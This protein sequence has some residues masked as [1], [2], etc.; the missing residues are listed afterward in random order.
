MRSGS[1]FDFYRILVC[2]D[3]GLFWG[4]KLVGLCIRDRIKRSLPTVVLDLLMVLAAWVASYWLRFNLDTIP[5]HFLQYAKTSAPVVVVVQGI[6]L[7]VFGVFRGVW[8]FTSLDDLS[9]ILKAVAVGTAIIMALM[10]LTVRLGGVPRSVPFLYAMLLT[11]FL[12]GPRLLYRLFTEKQ[13]AIGSGKRVLVV[14]AGQAGE[15]L[16]RDLLRNPDAHYQPVAIV[17]DKV[18]R[19]GRHVH[20]V[21]VV[22][23]CDEIVKFSKNL[24][25]D[26]I[27]LAIPSASSAQMQKIVG[28]CEESGVEF[29]TVPDLDALMSGQVSINELR[30]VSIEDILGRDQVTL[31]WE[32]INAGLTG[33]IIL[34]T[35]GGGSIGSELCRQIARIGPAKLVLLEN[36]EYNLYLIEK[37]LQ[38]EF[39]DISFDFLLGNVSDA[40]TV[41]RVFETFKP[42]IVFHAAAYKHVPMLEYQ[43]REAFKNNILGTRN[44]AV[45]ADKAGCSEF[46]LISTDKA[47]NPSN[48]MGASKRIAEIFCQNFNQRSRTNFITVRFGNV[49]GSA[50]SVIPLFREQ[51]AAGGPVTVTH[52][53]IER[54]FMTIPEAC[55]LIMQ[56][57]VIG[58]GGEIFVL[59]MGEPVKISFLAE[60]MIKLSGKEPGNDIEIAYTG[61]RPGEKLYE[62]LFHDR[63]QLEPTGHGKIQL[64]RHRTVEWD[65]L[66]VYMDTAEVACVEYNEDALIELIKELVPESKI[67][68]AE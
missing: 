15:M 1:V 54:Y 36:S 33:K 22:G 13:F 48:I 51:I 53:E 5:A 3:N 9:R 27:L 63:E 32:A 43:I 10:F 42:D 23:G 56:A 68:A 46:V 50:G 49:L 6:I 25:I 18:R 30:E 44:I 35:G 16:I 21:L 65:R 14:G 64:A 37:E 28:Y 2:K 12:A 40:M 61:L 17:D 55:Q 41:K 59:D 11:A 60:Q 24:E 38:R 47:V 20:G 45:E 19:H 58:N 52:R 66:D 4:L 8:R 62:E 39:V 29:R 7:H 26:L 67:E 31:D 57:S 34:V